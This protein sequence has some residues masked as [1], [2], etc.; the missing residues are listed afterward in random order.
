M[1][2][3][4][5]YSSELGDLRKDKSKISKVDF[6]VDETSL[7]LLLRRLTSGKGRTVIEIKGLPTNK[8]WC[9]GLAKDLKKKIGVG[10]SYKND[11][12]EIHGENYEQVT[13]FLESKNIVFKKIGG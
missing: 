10:G 4:L 11:F 7:Q 13:K 2:D 12:I 1:S 5:I 8:A 3:D 6:E 9:K